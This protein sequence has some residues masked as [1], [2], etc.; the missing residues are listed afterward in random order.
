MSADIAE[1]AKVAGIAENADFSRIV[2]SAETLVP[3]SRGYR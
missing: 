1:T 3:N 2:E